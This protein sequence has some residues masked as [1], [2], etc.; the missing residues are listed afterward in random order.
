MKRLALYRT[1][2]DETTTAGVL[3]EIVGD[4]DL[5]LVCDTLERG[6]EAPGRPG[7]YRIPAGTYRV[8]PRRFGGVLAG[9]RK[10]WPECPFVPEIKDVPGRT[11]ILLHPGNT[12]KDS[13][14]C[15]CTGYGHTLPINRPG[16]VAYSKEAFRDLVNLLA[17]AFA[18]GEEVTLDIKDLH[19]ALA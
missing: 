10:W 18:A 17:P 12:A 14:G 5:A 13:K 19:R 8:V 16:A 6:A 9:I 4:N 7:P 3:F 15:T 1:I 11:D 2:A